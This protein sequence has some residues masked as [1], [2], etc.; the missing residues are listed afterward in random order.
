M[1][2]WRDW[3]TG[4][5][6]PTRVPIVSAPGEDRRVGHRPSAAERSRAGD[7]LQT[8]RPPGRRSGLPRKPICDQRAPEIG[9]RA[10]RRARQRARKPG[11]R[12][13]RSRRASA[14]RA[15]RRRHTGGRAPRRAESCRS[16]RAQRVA[17]RVA[18]A[19]A[20]GSSI[21]KWATGGRSGSPSGDCSR[22]GRRGRRAGLAA[23]SVKRRAGRQEADRQPCARAR[24]RT[25]HR[26]P[27]G[28]GAAPAA[29]ASRSARNAARSAT[30]LAA[31]PSRRDR[32]RCA[33]R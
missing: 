18:R 19:S 33:K 14:G 28:D 25:G 22:A 24:Q 10:Q 26:G 12:G 31:S 11:C 1:T 32:R 23:S 6:P 13:A 21:P 9:V 16:W 17:D 3:G 20:P 2:L 15:R 4:A 30:R 7:R 5:A 8:R 27:A 29:T